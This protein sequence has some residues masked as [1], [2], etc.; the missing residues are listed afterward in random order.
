MLGLVM[1]LADQALFA[2]A[3]ASTAAVRPVAERAPG[4][5]SLAEMYPE[6]YAEHPAFS[7]YAGWDDRVIL[8]SSRVELVAGAGDTLVFGA[9]RFDVRFSSTGSAEEVYR[10]FFAANHDRILEAEPARP[11]RMLVPYARAFAVMRW[12]RQGG[13]AVDG[14][15]L[16]RVP[17]RRVFTPRHVAGLRYPRL[18]EIAPAA[19]VCFFGRFGP[20]R[21][22]DG[23]GRETRIA[24]VRGR[25][26]RVER[27]DGATLTVLRDGLGAPFAVRLREPGSDSVHEGAF[28]A[29]PGGRGD[30]GRPPSTARGGAPRGRPP[31]RADQA[32]HGRPPGGRRSP[33]REPVRPPGAAPGARAMSAARFRRPPARLLAAGIALAACRGDGGSP[34]K[35]AAP[36][37]PE[38]RPLVGTLAIHPPDSTA[39]SEWWLYVNGQVVAAGGDARQGTMDAGALVIVVVPGEYEVGVVVARPAAEDVYPLEWGARRV[40]VGAGDSVP[41]APETA[42]PVTWTAPAD[43]SLPYLPTG[44]WI[45]WL[46]ARVVRTYNQTRRDPVFAALNDAAARLGASPPATPGVFVDLPEALGGNRELDAAQVRILVDWL[47]R[48]R[49]SWFD[50]VLPDAGITVDQ[51]SGAERATYGDIEENVRKAKAEIENLGRIAEQLEE[52]ARAGT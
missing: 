22:V 12:L 5:H 34:A 2:L 49:W 1:A 48:V 40:T 45:T 14:T 35:T 51:L 52:A 15:E 33:A 29:G 18:D 19:P 43:S 47:E 23:A 38:V 36:P 11:L 4:Y 13:V 17:I 25:P 6:K 44:E 39:V 46:Y 27:A 9:T 41:V 3:F 31:P 32:P 24:Y 30:L 42:G 7:R 50:R 16:R 8:S 10:A 28:Y 21:I 20:V 26:I 37:P